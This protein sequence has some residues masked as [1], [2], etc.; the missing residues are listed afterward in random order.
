M[1][2]VRTVADKGYKEL[3]IE[4]KKELPN[5]VLPLMGMEEEN[6]DIN[7]SGRDFIVVN[8]EENDV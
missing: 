1:S 3:I 7:I 5:I 4:I 8:K 6:R 2:E